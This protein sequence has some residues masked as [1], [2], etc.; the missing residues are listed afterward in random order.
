MLF[1]INKKLNSYINDHLRLKVRY[2]LLD[3]H[4]LPLQ[5]DVFAAPETCNTQHYVLH[6]YTKVF[7]TRLLS[8]QLNTHAPSIR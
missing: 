8:D 5:P 4:S 3:T 7:S 6:P 1:V 2:K